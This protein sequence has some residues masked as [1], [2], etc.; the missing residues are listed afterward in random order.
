[1]S[2]AIVFPGMGPT[3][4]G[5]AAAF[6]RDDPVARELFARAA[7]AL[8]YPLAERF[9]ASEDDYSEAAQVAFLV[10]CLA[11]AAWAERELGVR[12]DL[13][14]GPS[15]G[16]KAAAAYSG[17]VD[18][19]TAVRM[20]AEI[21]RRT[22]EYFAVAHPGIVTHSFVRVAEPRLTEILDELDRRGVWHELS[23]RIDHDFVMLSLPGAELE[24]LD[25]RVRAAGGLS[26]YTMRPPMHAAAFAPLR[27][28]V[29]EKVLAGLRFADPRLPVLDDHDGSALTTGEQV[30]SMLLDSFVRAPSWPRVV[31]AMLGRGVTRVCVSGQDSLFGRVPITTRNFTVVAVNPR[32]TLAGR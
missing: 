25:G 22:E 1:M 6:M 20:T 7:D 10:N 3:R 19:E 12:A 17:A 14:A 13:C 9:T 21:A 8:G 26:L 23:C 28:T 5:E 32:L 29:E 11:L 18:F 15:F 30:R 31:E 27:R 2:T 24:W 16:G 4:Y